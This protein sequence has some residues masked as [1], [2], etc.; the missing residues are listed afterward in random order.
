M[1]K[2]NKP[3][4]TDF[5]FLDQKANLQRCSIEQR[6][7]KTP[8]YHILL[9][10]LHDYGHFHLLYHY[11]FPPSEEIRSAF[12]HLPIPTIK[13]QHL[14]MPEFQQHPTVSSSCYNSVYFSKIIIN[15]HLPE[16]KEIVIWFQTLPSLKVRGLLMNQVPPSWYDLIQEIARACHRLRYCRILC[17]G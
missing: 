17:S 13:S 5:T 6:Y 2:H 1:N 10:Q 16:K 8:L 11:S 3:V 4:K 7:R 14:L 9:L 12:D 15:K